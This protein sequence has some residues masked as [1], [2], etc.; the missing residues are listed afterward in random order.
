M[1]GRRLSDDR[2]PFADRVCAATSLYRERDV[3]SDLP[4]LQNGSAGTFVIFPDG[5]KVSLPTDQIVFPDDSNGAARVGF[6]G[7]SFVGTDQGRL[8]FLRVRE[9]QPEES[10][11]RSTVMT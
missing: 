1:A 7:M 10:L 5:V 3:I 2:R 9:L 8:V 11:P 4:I 6:G